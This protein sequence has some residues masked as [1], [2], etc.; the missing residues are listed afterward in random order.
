MVRSC[1]KCEN[2]PFPF[3]RRVT[4]ANIETTPAQGIAYTPF[5]VRCEDDERDGFRADRTKLWNAELPIAK[6]FEKQ[7]LEF[8][9][10]L[11]DL[12]DEQDTRFVF[13]EKRSEERTFGEKF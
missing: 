4:K 9:I 8:L 7:S 12:V 13:I 5:L 11:V 3:D 1:L 2:P 10:N 6:Y